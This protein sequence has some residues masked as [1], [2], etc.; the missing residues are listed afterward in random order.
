[1]VKLFQV[2]T[3]DPNEIKMKMIFD[4]VFTK[5]VRKRYPIYMLKLGK[6]RASDEYIQI[7]NKRLLYFSE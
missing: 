1:M 6:M 2:N 7:K 5:I 3:N 4:E